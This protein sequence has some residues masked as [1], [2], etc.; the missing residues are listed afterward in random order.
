M[1]DEIARVLKDTIGYYGLGE[2]R[3]TCAVL[4][5]NQLMHFY[6]TPIHSC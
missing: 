2:G 4:P 1:D 6:S 5:Y 3:L